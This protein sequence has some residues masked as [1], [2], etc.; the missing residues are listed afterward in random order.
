MALYFAPS[1]SMVMGSVAPEEQGIAS[2]ANNAI[3]EVGGALGVALLAAVFSAHGS[4]ASG[5]SY[6]DG[7]RPALWG[8][9]S[10]VALGAVA[11]LLTPR[12]RAA[13]RGSKV[14]AG[15]AES[16]SDAGEP[17]RASVPVA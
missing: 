16:A 12:A 15:G 10:A 9:A 8:G 2:G 1:A 13:L 6:V 3:R 14:A 4:Y 5:A 11:A 17:D 7:L